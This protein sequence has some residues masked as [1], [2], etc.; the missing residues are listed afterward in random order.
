MPGDG[1]VRQVPEEQ[2]RLRH[3]QGIAFVLILIAFLER[4]KKAGTHQIASSAGI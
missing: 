1:A 2:Q 4:L 3:A